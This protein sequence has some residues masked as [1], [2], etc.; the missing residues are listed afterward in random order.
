M[1]EKANISWGWWITLSLGSCAVIFIVAAA[2]AAAVFGIAGFNEVSIAVAA[3]LIVV[4]VVRGP[5]WA[6]PPLRNYLRHRGLL[7]R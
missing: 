7:V 6:I 4:V 1:V 2:I 3:A 5:K